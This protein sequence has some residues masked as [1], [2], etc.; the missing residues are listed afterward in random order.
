M[1]LGASPERVINLAIR[2]L[3][4]IL[5]EAGSPYRFDFLSIDVEGHEIE[6]LRGFDIA[7]WRPCL[8]RSRFMSLTCQGIGIWPRPATGLFAAM[9]TTGG[10]CRAIRQW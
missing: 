8:I 6:V 10:M 7:R 1:A 3:D 5:A 4:G 2:A 9:R